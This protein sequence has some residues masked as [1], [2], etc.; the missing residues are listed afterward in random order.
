M[1]NDT[2]TRRQWRTVLIPSL[3]SAVLAVGLWEA[4]P[5]L[6]SRAQ[7]Q[8]GITPKNSPLNA[9]KDRRDVVSEIAVT[10]KKLDT[11]MALLKSGQVRVIAEVEIK[12]PPAAPPPRN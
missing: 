3:I 8:P 4:L 11:L 7:A 2:T 10:N 9:I 5:R 6:T 1:A 12:K